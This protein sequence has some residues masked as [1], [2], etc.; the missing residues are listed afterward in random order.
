MGWA[1]YVNTNSPKQPTAVSMTGQSG[2]VF[3]NS[4]SGGAGF[5]DA[6]AART[7]LTDAVPTGAGWTISGDTVQT[8]C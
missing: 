4:R 6:G 1:N 3:A 8:N 5:A 2:R 7:F